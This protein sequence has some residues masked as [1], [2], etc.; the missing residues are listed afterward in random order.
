MARKTKVTFN[1]TWIVF[2]IIAYNLF[3]SDDEDKK[4]V[5]IVDQPKATVEEVST[6]K[7]I[8]LT[9]L[10]EEGTKVL[11]QVVEKVKEEIESK[12]S[13]PEEKRE[14]VIIAEPEKE[15][16]EVTELNPLNDQPETG[17]KKL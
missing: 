4:E 5:K 15:E 9:K 11:N 2:M 12:K 17:M 14:E 10:K 13:E 16:E 6:Q 7:G 8:D 1:F 3:F